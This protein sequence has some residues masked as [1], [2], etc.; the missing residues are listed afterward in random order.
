LSG[1]FILGNLG[2]HLYH[3]QIKNNFNNLISQSLFGQST[4]SRECRLLYGFFFPENP[5]A[6]ILREMDHL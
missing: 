6:A 1:A 4:S 3:F 5:Y 2:T